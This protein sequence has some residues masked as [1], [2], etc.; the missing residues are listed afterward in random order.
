MLIHHVATAWKNLLITLLWNGWTRGKISAGIGIHV[1]VD[2]QHTISPTDGATQ[3]RWLIN[4]KNGPSS[5]SFLISSASFR[6]SISH[7]QRSLRMS[8]TLLKSASSR[9]S[10]LPSSTTEPVPSV[11][12]SAILAQIVMLILK[13]DGPYTLF[14]RLLTKAVRNRPSVTRRPTNGNTIYSLLTCQSLWLQIKQ[15]YTVQW[16]IEGPMA[17]DSLLQ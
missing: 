12:L 8:L 9:Y 2:R 3:L 11:S 1:L 4:L 7:V 14:W 15:L 13:C 16:S 17:P 6:C 5:K 10:I